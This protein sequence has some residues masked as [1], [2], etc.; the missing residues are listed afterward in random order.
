MLS[1]MATDF[2][3]RSPLLVYPVAAL[4]IF[5]LVFAGVS[6]RTLLAPQERMDALARLPLH[7]QRGGDPP[8]EAQEDDHG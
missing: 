3:A 2:F 6:L 1:W 8:L 5:M 4:G 7:D